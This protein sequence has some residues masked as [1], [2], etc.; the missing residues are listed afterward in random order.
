[1][2]IENLI[3]GNWYSVNVYDYECVFKLRKICDDELYSY[4]YYLKNGEYYKT[5]N[6]TS[7]TIIEDINEV[8]IS[9]IYKYLPD[10]NIDKITFLRRKKIDELL[11]YEL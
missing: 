9:R 7:W 3:I 1:M 6:L 4:N 2:N 11:K 5:N 8:D 10:D